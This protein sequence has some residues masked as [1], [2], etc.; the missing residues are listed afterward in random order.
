MPRFPNAVQSL[1]YTFVYCTQAACEASGLN[2]YRQS[3]NEDLHALRTI[4][5]VRGVAAVSR[6]R[7]KYHIRKA[8]GLHL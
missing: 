4:L 7:A 8:V 6:G 1:D 2:P 3:G 5:G